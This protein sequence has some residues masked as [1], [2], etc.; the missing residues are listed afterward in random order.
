MERI[1]PEGKFKKD[2]IQKEKHEHLPT[3]DLEQLIEVWREIVKI[4]NWDIYAKSFP[5]LE[6]IEK[7]KEE[8][9][10]SDK[11][12]KDEEEWKKFIEKE[13]HINKCLECGRNFEDILYKSLR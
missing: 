4:I 12:L 1:N 3:R 13:N 11:P 2:Q 10:G 6:E 7:R 8:L 9:I 5:E